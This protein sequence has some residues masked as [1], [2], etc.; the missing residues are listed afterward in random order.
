[1]KCDLI[2]DDQIR[3]KLIQP[4]QSCAPLV[5]GSMP[6][7]YRQLSAVHSALAEIKRQGVEDAILGK[8]RQYKV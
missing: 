6:L 5:D 3:A 7:M 8:P 2:D 1:M 4:V